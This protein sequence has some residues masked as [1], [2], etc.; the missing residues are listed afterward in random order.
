MMF[1]GNERRTQQGAY[2]KEIG[3]VKNHMKDWIWDYHMD[4]QLARLKLAKL[5]EAERM[6]SNRARGQG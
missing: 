4:I 3:D 2:P 5:W 6:A 1:S